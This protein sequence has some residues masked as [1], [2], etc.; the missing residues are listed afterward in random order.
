MGI[1]VRYNAPYLASDHPNGIIKIYHYEQPFAPSELRHNIIR[2]EDS[3]GNVYLE[4]KYEQDPTSWHYAR[5]T[6]QLYGGFLYQFR[7]TQLQ[8]VPTNPVYINIPAVRVEVMNPDFGLETYTFN[9]RGDL[10]DRRYRLN[11]DSSFRV[12]V[13]QYEFD[14]QGNLS[15]ITN[16]DG[17][18]ELNTY[19]FGNPD[20]RMRGKLLQKE[21]TAASGFPSPSRIIWKAKYEPTYQLL[22]EEKNELEATS[23]YKYDFDINPGVMTNSGK[24]MAVVHPDVTLPDGTIQSSVT[25]YENNHKGQITATILPTGVRQEMIYGTAGDEKSRLIKQVF[26]VG[27]LNIENKIKY[28]GIGFDTESIDGNGNLTGS[29]PKVMMNYNSE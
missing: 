29:V 25:K 19:D 16:P 20:P 7:Y 15:I 24:L 11:K 1:L 21:L 27:G 12:V 14:E 13:W 17:S 10:L 4:N 8:W 9:Y 23:K 18:Q 5:V 3:K 6:E 2:V 28:D 26:D 22:T